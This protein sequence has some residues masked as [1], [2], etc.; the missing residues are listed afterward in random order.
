MMVKSAVV[1]G[2]VAWTMTASEKER[3]NTWDRKV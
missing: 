2:S 1:Y 3:L